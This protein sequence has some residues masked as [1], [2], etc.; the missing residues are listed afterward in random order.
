MSEKI[1]SDDKLLRY[2]ETD[3]PASRTKSQIDGVL[4]EYGVQDVY[5]HWEKERVEKNEPANIYVLFKIEEVIEGLPVKVG[6]KVEYPIIWDR[7]NSLA[8]RP[9]NKVE[10]VNWNVSMRALHWFIYTHLNSAYAMKSSKTVAFLPFIQSGS[11]KSMR[12]LIVPKLS[13]YKAL[14]THQD[15]KTIE[16]EVIPP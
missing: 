8:K 7:G 16:P 11:G 10:K 4:A 3:I 12:E 15:R 5:W 6:V 14:E 13:E 2:K 1:Y 9:E